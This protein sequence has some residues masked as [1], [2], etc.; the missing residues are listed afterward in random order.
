[1]LLMT[2]S[3]LV[4]GSLWWLAGPAPAAEGP[5]VPGCN[6]RDGEGRF[7][8]WARGL[9]GR[10]IFLPEGAAAARLTPLTASD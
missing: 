1:L 5:A 2:E 4:T 3:P 9:V 8:F 7:S 6:K 10:G